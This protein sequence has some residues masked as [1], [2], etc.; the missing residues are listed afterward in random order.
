MLI[1]EQKSKEVFMEIRIQAI[2]FEASDRLEAF[3]EKK[4]SKLEQY[5]DKILSAEV[6]MKVIKPETAQNKQASIL[7]KIKN[8]DCFAEKTSDTFEEA[9]NQAAEALEK[10]LV[11]I[12]EKIRVK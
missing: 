4:V 2:H 1:H 11:K 3:V 12:K 8:G 9:I 10:Q 6:I 5:Y 7:L